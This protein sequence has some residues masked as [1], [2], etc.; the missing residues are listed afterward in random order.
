MARLKVLTVPDPRLR[1]KAA[2]VTVVDKAVCTLMD[3]MVETMHA[4]EG[5]GLAATQ[6]GVLLR[7]IVLDVTHK[8]PDSPIFKMANPEVLWQS[9]ELSVN[10][11]GCLSVP[12]QYGLVSRPQAIRLRYIDEHGTPQERDIDGFLAIA[13]QHEIDHLDGKLFIDYLPPLKRDTLVRK[14]KRL[15]RTGSDL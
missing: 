8:V 14:V 13:I 15:N 1:Q 9:A 6:V 10:E 7:V 5:C 11:E 4:E 12:E 2:P 3:D